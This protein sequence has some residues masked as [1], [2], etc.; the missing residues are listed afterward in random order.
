[1]VTHDMVT[2]LK[3][4]ASITQCLIQDKAFAAKKLV[5]LKL[6]QDTARILL[7]QV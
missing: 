2:P 7:A 4:M 3:C 5:E 1:M 6:V